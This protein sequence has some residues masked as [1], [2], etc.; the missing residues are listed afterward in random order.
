MSETA[1]KIVY[2]SAAV[3]V[4]AGIMLTGVLWFDRRGAHVRGEDLAELLA[5]VS[6]RQ[7]G[8]RIVRTPCPYFPVDNT[9]RID[10]H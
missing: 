7:T 4:S 9:D 10:R 5:A 1:N 6:E 2:G 8:W 3:L